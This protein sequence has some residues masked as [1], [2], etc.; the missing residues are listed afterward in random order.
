MLAALAPLLALAQSPDAP[1]LQYSVVPGGLRSAED[2]VSVRRE[3]KAVERHYRYFHVDEAQPVRLNRPRLAY[4]SYRVGG[5]IFWTRNTVMIPA[6]EVLFSDGHVRIRA[7]SGA[8]ISDRP[9]SPIRLVEPTEKQL[10]ARCADQTGLPPE[11]GACSTVTA[12][13]RMAAASSARSETADSTRTPRAPKD[14][15]N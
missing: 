7:K 13:E 5:E 8:L 15:A 9:M 3:D 6:G 11:I 14:S 4:V 2:I 1:T 10:E 12:A